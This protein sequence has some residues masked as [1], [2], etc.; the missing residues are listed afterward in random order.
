M[1]N[2]VPNF[3]IAGGSLRD[4][5]RPAQSNTRASGRH[6]AHSGTHH[7]QLEIHRGL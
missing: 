2:Q 5:Q 3:A 6:L 1:P 7:Q 4:T